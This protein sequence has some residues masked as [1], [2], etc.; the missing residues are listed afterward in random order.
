MDFV[1][2]VTLVGRVATAPRKVPGGG[3]VF[4]LFQW[5]EFEGQGE[6]PIYPIIAGRG[7]PPSFLKVNQPVIVVGRVR[8]RNFDQ[9]IPRLVAKALRRAGKGDDAQAIVAQ[10]PPGL[11]EPRVAVE[12]VADHIAITDL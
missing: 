5:Q 7:E 11:R 9:S 6:V 1:N 4:S 8:T 2:R 12:I 10:L 3:Y